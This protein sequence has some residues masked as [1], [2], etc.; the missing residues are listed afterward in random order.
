MRGGSVKST[1]SEMQQLRNRVRDLESMRERLSRLYFSQVETGKARMEKL[2][3]ILEVVTRLNSSLDIDSLLTQIVGAVQKSLGFRIVLLRILDPETRSLRARAFAGLSADAIRKLEAQNVELDTFLSWL[4]DEFRVSRSFFISHKHTFSRRLP[5]GVVHDLGMREDWEWHE[6]DVLFVPLYTRDGE[7]MAYLSVDDP[8]DRLVPSRETIEML[9]VFGNHVVVAL[10]NARLVQT[11]AAHGRELE[12]ANRRMGEVNQLKSSFLSAVSHELRTPLTSIHA[13][14]DSL[15]DDLSERTGVEAPLRFVGILEEEARR[16]NDLID[17]VLSFSHL[18]RG[19]NPMEFKL[20]DARQPVAIAAE[21]LRPLA[22]AKKVSLQTEVPDADIRIE[23]DLD[24]LKQLLLHL[25]GNAVKFTAPGGRVRIAAQADG[26]RGLV[27]TV[28]DTGIGIP[29]NQLERVFE[30]F[31]QVDQSLVRRFGGTGLG[32]ALCKSI[33]EVHGGSITV[34]SAVG[35]GSTFTVRLPKRA[36]QRLRTP[37]GNA[38]APQDA[39]EALRLLLAVTASVLGVDRVALFVPAAGNTARLRSSVGLP[40]R[41]TKGQ[42]VPGDRGIAG[43]VLGRGET[44]VSPDPAHDPRLGGATYPPLGDGP[45]AAVP[46]LHEGRTIGALA[47]AF[48]AEPDAGVRKLMQGLAERV[49]NVLAQAQRAAESQEA[50]AQA[51]EALRGEVTRLS[52]GRAASS[53][54]VRLAR[55]LADALGLPGESAACVAWAAAIDVT[56]EALAGPRGEEDQPEAVRRILAHR[57]ERVDGTGTPLGL[58]GD[59][60]DVGARILA[61]AGTFESASPDVR[62]SAR[63]EE[64]RARAGREFDPMVVEALVL[65]GV[66]DGWLDRGWAL[67]PSDAADAA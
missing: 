52:L 54:R 51:A 27:L 17:S 63:I 37:E 6:E 33:A 42:D 57:H 49:A 36:P 56:E 7:L 64:L 55:R 41:A 1:W 32:L 58:V 23:A 8:V 30:R 39:D 13:Y 67:G 10:E 19:S 61:V 11:L 25:G 14:L 40:E 47:A 44:F 62:A 9:E 5:N 31:Y 21:A 3:R 24:L 2:H 18:E 60:I 29:E 28:S 45:V 35:E 16:L 22:E 53:D 50:L 66:E 4:D 43:W 34:E 59:E 15:R 46:L 65:V 20:L 48:A 12:A 38:G 26:D